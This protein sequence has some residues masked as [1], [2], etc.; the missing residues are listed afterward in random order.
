MTAAKAA[1]LNAKQRNKQKKKNSK[2]AKQREQW[3]KNSEISLLLNLFAIKFKSWSR[4]KDSKNLT[5]ITVITF[6]ESS[7]FFISF[8]M[9]KT[10]KSDHAMKKTIVWK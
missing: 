10:I 2:I 1:E 7:F 4:L 8:M 3:K 6:N 5:L 9:F